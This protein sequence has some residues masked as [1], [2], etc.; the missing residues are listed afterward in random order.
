MEILPESPT[1]SDSD[2]SFRVNESL[3]P[4]RSNKTAVTT[5]V[6]FDGLL[7]EPLLLKEDLKGGC[8]GQLWPAGMLLAEYLLRRHPVDLA[9]K[10]MSV[11][12]LTPRSSVLATM[13]LADYLI[14]G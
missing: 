11:L 8:G 2:A 6:N 9:D 12:D 3:A 1:S 13:W 7:K 14:G 4:L 10:T 5:S